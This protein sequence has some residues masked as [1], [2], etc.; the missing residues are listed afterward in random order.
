MSAHD[1]T[2]KSG[3]VH[4]YNGGIRAWHWINALA[5]LVLAVTGY[6][7]GSP[8]PSVPGEAS[9]NFLFG[10]IRFAHFS[11]AYII[12][13]GFFARAYMALVGDHHARVIFAPP[14]FDKT[15]WGGALHQ[16]RWYL[17]LE[18]EPRKYVGHNPLST[19]TMFIMYTLA[20]LVMICTGF[21][22]YAEGAGMGSWQYAL[23]GWVIPLVGN[24]TFALHTIHHTFMWVIIIFVIIHIYTA[25]REESMSRQTM[26]STMISGERT[27]R[28]DRPDD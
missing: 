24:N 27:F 9:D 25:L 28:D 8:P 13:I 26:I 11:A 12:T 23:F 7:I 10:Y 4:V 17:F 18:N 6:F 16:L 15:F 19:I 20:M 22:M 14:I 2:I 3:T 1:D 5:I 21:A